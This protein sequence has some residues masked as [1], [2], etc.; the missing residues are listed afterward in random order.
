MKLRF[1]IFFFVSVLLAFPFS[2][3]ADSSRKNFGEGTPQPLQKN[4]Y[5]IIFN[6]DIPHNS[7]DDGFASII[8]ERFGSRVCICDERISVTDI[9]D[10]VLLNRKC[11]DILKKYSGSAP[12]AVIFYGS[13]AIMAL[14]SLF[15][16]VWAGVPIIAVSQTKEIL[17]NIGVLQKEGDTAMLSVPEN[18]VSV[19]NYLRHYN[20]TVVYWNY[21]LSETLK[22]VFDFFPE[23]RKVTLVTDGEFDR[24][25]LMDKFKLIMS[26]KY[27][28][29][30]YEILS[31]RDMGTGNLL[32]KLSSQDSASVVLYDS[33]D[34]R[35]AGKGENFLQKELKD[36]VCGVSRVPLFI[37]RDVNV[38][39]GDAIGGCYVTVSKICDMVGA[40]LDEVL[41][42]NSASSIPSKTVGTPQTILD[43]YVLSKYHVAAKTPVN[44]VILF[45][46]PSFYKRNKTAVLILL[47]FVVVITVIVLAYSRRMAIHA[48]KLKDENDLNRRIISSL[49]GV[50]FL[51]SS[52]GQ[53]LRR[54]SPFSIG[55]FDP[56]DDISKYS[57]HDFI[58]DP[59]L[60]RE[61]EQSFSKTLKEKSVEN[62]NFSIH[63]DGKDIWLNA[64][65]IPYSSDEV[66]A[67]FRDV[68]VLVERESRQQEYQ[69]M[70]E[71]LVDNVPL[72]VTMKN[73]ET[74]KYAVWNKSSEIYWGIPSSE[75]IGHTVSECL[76]PAVAEKVS[77]YDNLAAAG[78]RIVN[79]VMSF[80]FK[81]EIRYSLI[82]KILLR[83]SIRN[84]N[85]ILTSFLDITDIK[86]KERTIERLNMEYTLV[87]KALHLATWNW[88]IKTDIMK[89]D[90]VNFYQDQKTGPENRVSSIS[91]SQYVGNIVE[92]DQ[93]K[94][95]DAIRD[96]KNGTIDTITREY[97]CK[98]L[99]SNR[100]VWLES[101][102]IVSER[103]DT[104]V[105]V[106]IVGVSR[107]ISDRKKVEGSLVEAKAQAE[108]SNR[109]KSFF[110]ANMSHEIRTPL[111]AIVGFSNII[112][113]TEDPNERR[114]Y[115]EIIRSNNAMLL[116]LVNDILD[117]LKIEAGVM[118]FTYTDVN[119]NQ[120][121]S[122]VVESV[123]FKMK[124]SGS[125]VI[126]EEK[127]LDECIMRTDCNRLT[128]VLTNF[129]TNAVK[130][131]KEGSI[132]LGY[133]MEDGGSK[134]RFF[135]SDTGCGIAPENVR[136]I[137]GRFVKL[138]PYSQGSGIGL[139]L[140]EVIV[141]TMKGEI[142]VDSTLGK[143]STFWAEFP[144]SICGRPLGENLEEAESEH[145]EA[146]GE[147]S[148]S[149]QKKILVAED[150]DSNFR[151][152][153]TVIGKRYNLVHAWNGKE[154]VDMFSSEKPDLV[155]MDI[156]MPI[157]D[158]YE[159]TSII[160]RTDPEAK[161]IAVTAF[162]T[163]EDEERINSTGFSGFLA[164]P[165]NFESLKS[166]VFD[167][168]YGDAENAEVK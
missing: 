52:R 78:E 120:L 148:A 147:E 79:E 13:G 40:S 159:A 44:S 21:Y 72:S 110:L 69:R 81:G 109:L 50:V 5:V 63:H 46:P 103:D 164:K 20:A 133:K 156:K 41:S 114:S 115:A 49:D 61:I 104:G 146:G 19:E 94:L 152:I 67:F 47:F 127:P 34:V 129:L 24:L 113:E 112:A 82:S 70:I 137:F 48:K 144:Y 28:Q 158:G 88:N 4:G 65:F 84:E 125:V 98:S 42:G 167:S 142:G 57:Y 90:Y 102:A 9:S 86:Q 154:A 66:M 12:E 26:E 165:I 151:L 155:L 7:F 160:R 161:V 101:Y 6:V 54:L 30:D 118:E 126:R 35:N 33:F 15:D 45:K 23:K 60:L 92:E 29:K 153:K 106:N 62:L 135:C 75:I 32:R 93:S 17:K 31:S 138:N 51:I 117:M 3:Y 108:E 77:S 100:I 76:P 87:Q 14:T 145:G 163:R 8:E 128:Q 68:T 74:G 111:N 124:L 2:L 140:S 89:V 162:A 99:I 105:P 139:S 58:S 1:S 43:Y 141:H 38:K 16:N 95:N 168:I 71:T 134:I 64:K 123:N 97:R 80:D 130:F 83:Y 121:I 150:N 22:L 166:I 91:M 39:E 131:T 122:E 143:G 119:I 25:Y 55:I 56:E 96:M 53:F 36:I 27:P 157:M 85:W 10:S 18:T 37:L 59:T 107:D 116:R 73:V 11:D 132:V 136:T 149:Q